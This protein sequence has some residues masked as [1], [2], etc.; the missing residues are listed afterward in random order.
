[1]L[2]HLL[3]YPL[4]NSARARKLTKDE[5]T[6]YMDL[7]EEIGIEDENVQRVLDTGKIT[8]CVCGFSVSSWEDGSGGNCT[9]ACAPELDPSTHVESQKLPKPERGEDRRRARAFWQQIHLKDLVSKVIMCRIN[10]EDVKK[11]TSLLHM[12]ECTCVHSFTWP[13]TRQRTMNT[14]NLSEMKLGS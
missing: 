12:H 1:M 14:K 6:Q 3:P 13:W 5:M 9:Q 8:T 7:V 10:K 2:W 11:S 4:W